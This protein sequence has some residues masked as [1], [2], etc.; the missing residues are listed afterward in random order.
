MVELLA[1]SG[2]GAA[3]SIA[4]SIQI[5]YRHAVFCSGVLAAALVLLAF[6]PKRWLFPAIIAISLLI[7]PAWTIS[8]THGDCGYLK[9]DISRL[10]TGITCFA[11]GLQVASIVVVRRKRPT[12]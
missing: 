1:C 6:F 8:A 9:R 5:G 11:A 2:P 7:H 3:E 10:F 12:P 4:L